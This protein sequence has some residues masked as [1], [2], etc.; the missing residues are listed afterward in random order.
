LDGTSSSS[1]KEARCS[2]GLENTIQPVGLG[3]SSATTY[4]SSRRL[5]TLYAQGKLDWDTYT[6]LLLV[7][8]GR[9]YKKISQKPI[10]EKDIVK[11]LLVLK[12]KRPD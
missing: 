5:R 8:P 7:I 2:V 10:L 9:R 3:K 1:W 12:E 11:T 6:R 4:A